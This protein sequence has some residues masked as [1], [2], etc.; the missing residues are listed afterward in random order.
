MLKP[1]VIL[2]TMA[3]MGGVLALYLI[4][5]LRK[6]ISEKKEINRKVQ[7]DPIVKN[8]PVFIKRN[9]ITIN[10]KLNKNSWDT[11]IPLVEEEMRLMGMNPKSFTRD[12]TCQLINRLIRKYYSGKKYTSVSDKCGK[13]VIDLVHT[14]LQIAFETGPEYQKV[15]KKIENK[16]KNI[17]KA[18]IRKFA[19]E[20]YT[21]KVTDEMINRMHS[22][23]RRG[24]VADFQEEMQ[25]QMQNDMQMQMQNDMQVQMQ[26]DMQN[27]MMMQMQ[28]DMQ[29][30]MM[31]QMQMDMQ[32]QMMMQMQND[33]QNQ[34]INQM[35]NDMH[36]QMM[37]D[38]MH[39]MHQSEMAITPMHDGGHMMDM[40]NMHMGGM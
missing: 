9:I 17:S 8:L 35:Q 33:M 32:N 10:D 6:K 38:N 21:G 24:S 40:N 16:L 30:Q 36:N 23:I 37:A 34:M 11:A 5:C 14:N 25:N 1:G 27:Q 28:M 4:F 7:Q 39:S 26:M 19:E 15:K 20:R 13:N 31:M 12:E 29:N 22:D 18:E 2:F 3:I